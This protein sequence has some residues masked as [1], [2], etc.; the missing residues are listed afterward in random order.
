MCVCS[1]KL[2][3]QIFCSEMFGKLATALL[4]ISTE[5]S[6]QLLG[7]NMT[8]CDCQIGSGIMSFRFGHDVLLSGNFSVSKRTGIDIL[9]INPIFENGENLRCKLFKLSWLGME[10]PVFH[11]EFFFLFWNPPGP[12]E[13]SRENGHFKAALER[14]KK[15]VLKWTFVENGPKK[16]VYVSYRCDVP[17]EVPNL[18][19]NTAITSFRCTFWDPGPKRNIA[20]IYNILNPEQ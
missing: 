10:S 12:N 9:M 7:I 3:F 16:Y 5:E 19:K 15:Y 17:F 13:C 20:L 18:K 6:N 4:W 14:L 11:S 1:L 8:S 2:E